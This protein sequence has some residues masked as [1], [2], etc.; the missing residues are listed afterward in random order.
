MCHNNDSYNY[1]PPFNWSHRFGKINTLLKENPGIIME[2][3]QD[4][5]DWHV[6]KV[7]QPGINL[8]SLL[9]K[10]DIQDLRTYLNKQRT[11]ADLLRGF[12]FNRVG[13]ETE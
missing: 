2:K 9:K 7:T 11:Q 13:P 3:R 1:A 8:R 4:R 12:K 5:E 10:Y 6:L